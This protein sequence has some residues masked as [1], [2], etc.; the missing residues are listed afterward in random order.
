MRVCIDGRA[1]AGA[2]P[3]AFSVLTLREE[4]EIA[5]AVVGKINKPEFLRVGDGG[6]AFE[7]QE[8]IGRRNAFSVEIVVLRACA[9]RAVV[10]IGY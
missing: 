1:V 7:D 10:G 5:C 6:R 4:Q 8:D 3:T 2:G 9:L